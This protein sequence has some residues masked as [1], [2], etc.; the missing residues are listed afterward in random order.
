MGAVGAAVPSASMVVVA[1]VAVVV[2]VVMFVISAIRQGTGHETVLM[3]VEVA[4]EVE[5]VAESATSAI[6]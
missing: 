6:R 3:L 2:V 1:V 5:V 4:V